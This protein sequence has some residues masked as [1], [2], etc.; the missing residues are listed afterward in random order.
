MQVLPGSQICVSHVL[1]NGGLLLPLCFDDDLRA[2][3]QGPKGTD[4]EWVR[5]LLSS[6]F[7]IIQTSLGGFLYGK[8]GA[9][10]LLKGK[11]GAKAR[12]LRSFIYWV[13]ASLVFLNDIV[14]RISSAFKNSITSLQGCSF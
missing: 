7:R 12:L 1:C 2:E 9:Y 11:L 10:V 6:P 5:L 4:T 13:G 3:Q 14:M 8:A